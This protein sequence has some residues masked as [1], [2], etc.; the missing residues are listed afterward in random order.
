MIGVLPASGSAT[1][2]NGLPKFILPIKDGQ[3][4]LQWHV[5]LMS[6]ACTSVTVITRQ[7]WLPLVQDLM[8]NASI[9]QKEPSTMADA[10]LHVA[11]NQ[12]QDVIIGMPD[13]YIHNSSDNFY[14]KLVEGH[15]D[16]IL[17]TWDFVPETMRGKV[18]Q[19]L[20]DNEGNVLSVVD[21]DFDCVYTEM[22]GAI[23]F[24][25]FS[26]NLI[27]PVGGSVISRINQWIA[28]GIKVTRVKMSGDYIDAGTIEGVIHLYTS[29]GNL[30]K[31]VNKSI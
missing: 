20:A 7:C 28:E 19:V 12:S 29:I 15:G 16:V 4:L 24:R 14:Q 21:K 6:I 30:D 5:E 23:L 13:V 27:D 10:V 17:A 22:W 2:L 18:G 25:N 11:H 1:R 8:L 9:V 3:S 26:T 31:K